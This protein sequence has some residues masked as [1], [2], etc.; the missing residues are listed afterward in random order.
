M[1][2]WLY[3]SLLGRFFSF[4]ILY[5]FGRTPWTGDQPVSSPLHCT[6]DST[7]RINAHRHQCFKWDS[8]P[9]SQCLSG[10]TFHAL[11]NTATMIGKVAFRS[12]KFIPSSMKTYRLVEELRWGRLWHWHHDIISPKTSRRRR[13]FNA[14]FVTAAIKSSRIWCRGQWTRLKEWEMC[15]WKLEKWLP[16]SK[17]IFIKLFIYDLFQLSVTQ[18]FFMCSTIHR[19]APRPFNFSNSHSCFTDNI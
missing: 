13:D 11:D 12:T 9:W 4:L 1:C 3:S 2:L 18:D 8:N 16:R 5:T 6:Q 19:C 15:L 10:L 7:N 14:E 17:C